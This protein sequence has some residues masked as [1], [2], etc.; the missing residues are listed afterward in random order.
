VEIE[1]QQEE[2]KESTQDCED[3][4][5]FNLEAIDD[6]LLNNFLSRRV[7]LEES[8][9]P[10]RQFLR[11]L[12]EGKYKRRKVTNSLEKQTGFTL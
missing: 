8:L 6:I 9:V 10:K 4:E 2:E 11:E 1:L 3:Q 5:M 7:P 12:L